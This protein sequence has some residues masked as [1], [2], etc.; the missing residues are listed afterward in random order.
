MRSEWGATI[1]FLG[2]QLDIFLT[3]RRRSILGSWPRRQ[4]VDNLSGRPAGEGASPDRLLILGRRGCPPPSGS[5]P[6]GGPGFCRE[7]AGPLLVASHCSSMQGMIPRSRRTSSTSSSVTRSISV[8][9]FRAPRSM[10][11]RRPRS[12]CPPPW[13]RTYVRNHGGQGQ[14]ASTSNG[15][16]RTSGNPGFVHSCGSATGRG[17]R[18]SLGPVKPCHHGL[19]VQ[20]RTDIRRRTPTA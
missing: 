17:P 12:G 10:L 13:L 5:V 16:I 7:S 2:E 8:R 9:R 19:R 20:S 11:S 18:S 6:E 1:T 14:A 4:P 15:A 3:L